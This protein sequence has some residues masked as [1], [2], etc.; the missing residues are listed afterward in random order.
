MTHKSC[1]PEL[2]SQLACSTGLRNSSHRPWSESP[3]PQIWGEAFKNLANFHFPRHMTFCLSLGTQSLSLPPGG[4]VS[5]QRK[6]PGSPLM[7]WVSFSYIAAYL[8]MLVICVE[9]KWQE[10]TSGFRS[11]SSR[12]RCQ[13]DV[14]C[15]L[16]QTL[17]IGWQFPS[18]PKFFGNW[19]THKKGYLILK[20]VFCTSIQIWICVSLYQHNVSH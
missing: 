1:S 15:W 18:I 10:G 5:V 2:S 12:E 11:D 6:P 14:S 3:P 9:W 13:P 17:F 4:R 20:N 8:E 7:L 16:L 19:N